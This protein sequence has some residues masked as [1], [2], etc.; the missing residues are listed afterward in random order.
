MDMNAK[1]WLAATA[2]ATCKA[3]GGAANAVPFAGNSS[4][5][6]DAPGCF[7]CYRSNGNTVL[8]W[9]V[10]DSK[11]TAV[12]VNFAGNTDANDV[13]IARLDWYNAASFFAPDFNSEWNLT[14]NITLPAPNVDD[15]EELSIH[16]DNTR[17]PSG[18]RITLENLTGLA[19][20]A[21]GISITDIKY[22]VVGSGSLSGLNWFNPKG[23]N[24]TLYITAD[25]R[26]VPE[27][28]SLAQLGAGLGG[29]G[30][31]RRRKSA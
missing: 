13:V 11:L 7:V 2:L 23:G 12:P 27:P 25:F 8:H 6:F 4:G 22:S 20:A 10:P 15:F 21:A 14:I 28:A 26:A 3:A 9:G 30:Y 5:T 1:L 31:A 29:L 24:S 19:L 16:I 17:N 18:D